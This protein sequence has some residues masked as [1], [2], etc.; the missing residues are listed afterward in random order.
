MAVMKVIKR[1]EAGTRSAR[2]LRKKG[3]IPGVI[4]G[5]GE[6]TESITLQEHEVELAILHGERLLEIDCEGKKQNVLIKDLQYDTF[7]Q[8]VLH[9]DLARVHLDERVEVTVQ[10]V[11]RGTP[12]GV[13]EESGMLQQTA[14]QVRIECTVQ[15]IPEEIVV[16][17]TELK[18]GDALTGAD[19]PL[20]D[21]AKLLDD[22]ASP[23]AAVR[24]VAEEE[25]EAPEQGPAAAEPE[26]VG[27]EK[28]EE[29]RGESPGKG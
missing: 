10:I 17:V 2:R 7:G 13:T 20:P 27:E 3:L 26:V 15:A 16:M 4:Y 11:L 25:A 14:A 24:L 1:E 12:V 23:V 18:V 22:P 21:G 6:A 19:L 5:H 28:P 9:V 8:Q 29:P